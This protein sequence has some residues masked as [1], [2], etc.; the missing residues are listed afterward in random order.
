MSKDYY[1]IMAMPFLQIKESNKDYYIIMAMPFLQIKESNV[2][3][4]HIERGLIVS[5]EINLVVIL[6]LMERE[7]EEFHKR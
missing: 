4:A 7:F 5:K 1:I 3:E 2:R 6:L